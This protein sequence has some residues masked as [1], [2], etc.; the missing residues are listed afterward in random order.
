MTSGTIVPGMTLHGLEIP[1]SASFTASYATVTTYPLN[2]T[3]V[4]QTSWPY[5][6]PIPSLLAGTSVPASAYITAQQSG[7]ANLIGIYT[8]SGT[9]GVIG[10]EAMTVQPVS[11]IHGSISGSTL[12][13]TSTDSAANNAWA[14]YVTPHLTGAGI[15]GGTTIT[16][17]LTGTPLANGISV[18]TYSL[19]A[20]I[21]PIGAE[22]MVVIL[23]PPAN[24]FANT[25]AH[26]VY[27]LTVTAVGSGT[28]LAGQVVSGSGI[29]NSPTILSQLTVV[30]GIG[31]T[32]TYSMSLPNTILSEAMTSAGTVIM[33]NV[34]VLNQ[35]TGGP[36]YGGVG[37]YTLSTSVGTSASIPLTAGTTIQVP[38]NGYTPPIY[39][40]ILFRVPV[41]VPILFAVQIAN[42]ATLPSDIVTKI[43]NAVIS[44]FA[45]GDGGPAARIGSNIIAS[46]YY[47]PIGATS[48][49]VQIVSVLLGTTTPTLPS[50]QVQIDQ[51]PTIIAANISVTLV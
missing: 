50:V 2:V 14:N 32:G 1:N 23:A 12:T 42:I 4:D 26:N 41:D 39:Y 34:T 21:G 7:S 9:P 25:Y 3:Y 16:A 29:S 8:V 37:T 17:Q 40:P 30:G 11:M 5:V 24:I 49:S 36:P 10:T 22:D 31:G 46:R 27:T 20:S 35:L 48:T 38:D 19:S 15:P 28:L 43:K 33:S 45:G 44:A 13:V 6:V 51:R 18:G 47:A